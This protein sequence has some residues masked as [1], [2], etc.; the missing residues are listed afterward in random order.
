MKSR[1]WI[2]WVVCAVFAGGLVLSVQA[3]KE[4][5][6]LIL[7]PR[8]KATQQLGLDIANRYPTM[9]VSYTVAKNGTISLHGWARTRWVNITPDDY[10]AGNFFKKGPHSALI[11]EKAGAPVPEKLVPPVDWCTDVAKIS[12]TQLR[13]LIHL[14]GQYFDFNYKDWKW[15]SQRYRLSVD[16][17]NPEG[18]NMAWYHKRL[19]EH[20]KSGKPVG[21]DDLQYWTSLRQTVVAVPAAEEKGTVDDGEVTTDPFTNSVPPAIVMGAGDV[22]EEEGTIEAEK[23]ATDAAEPETTSAE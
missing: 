20:L 21:S 1:R 15:F 3:R 18:L 9:L 8:E 10:A 4:E 19:D 7:I 22:P 6:T 17:I 23:E 2:K 12:T 16:A 5:I 13:P 14:L 11:V